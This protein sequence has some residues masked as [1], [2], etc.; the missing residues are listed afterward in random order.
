MKRVLSVLL[1]VCLIVG[2]C[3]MSVSAGGRVYNYIFD[4]NGVRKDASYAYG[5]DGTHIDS[6]GDGWTWDKTTRTLTLSGANFASDN[7][8]F[9]TI[10]LCGDATI[11]LT[12]GTKNT[13]SSARDSNTGAGIYCDGTLTVE[14]KG[15]LELIATGELAKYGEI[16][17]CA[18]ER[19]EIQDGNIS[20]QRLSGK[21]EIHIAGGNAKISSAGYCGYN[22]DGPFD[23]N[24]EGKRITLSI[25]GGVLN[26]ANESDDIMSLYSNSLKGNSL[27][28]T[29]GAVTVAGSLELGRDYQCTDGLLSVSGGTLTVSELRSESLYVTGGTVT[30]TGSLELKT[31]GILSVKNGVLKVEQSRNYNPVIVKRIEIDNAD[32]E[33]NVGFWTGTAAD[34]LIIT[35]VSCEE[36]NI[37]RGVGASMLY[38][39]TNPFDLTHSAPWKIVAAPGSSPSIPTPEPTPTPELPIDPATGKLYAPENLKWSQNTVTVG[40]VDGEEEIHIIPM[41]G[42]IYW[43]VEHPG[44]YEF[45]FKV[46]RKSNPEPFISRVTSARWGTQRADVLWLFRDE[47]FLDDGEY[48]FTV[49]SRANPDGTDSAIDSEVVVSDVW[50][51]KK[52]NQKLPSLPKSSVKWSGSY[53]VW[54]P[55]EKPEYTGGYEL[56]VENKEGTYSQNSASFYYDNPNKNDLHSVLYECEANQYYRYRIKV[57]SNDIN[58]YQHSDWSEWS[59]YYYWNGVDKLPDGSTPTSTPTPT[60]PPTSTPTPTPK[61]NVGNFNDVH[62]GDYFA[63]AV[64]WAVENGIT[65]G[66]GSSSTF[67]P[68]DTCTRAEIMTFIWASEGRPAPSAPADF[69]D[70]PSLPAFR[71]AISWAVEQG[72]TSGMGGGKFGATMPCTRVQAVTFL[73]AAAGRPQPTATAAFSDMTGN[74]VYDAAISWA[75]ENQITTGAGNNRFN[76]GKRCSRAE[77]VT[78]LRAA[79]AEKS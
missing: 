2:L 43:E 69:V 29:G 4:E 45:N 70:M 56:Q 33:S 55:F 17:L 52:P 24:Q 62:E 11:Y 13:V 61:P 22:V 27:N 31:S 6:K 71:S 58:E 40:Y 26:V 3:P 23:S 19:L 36:V 30:I 37:D 41:A 16:E 75:V 51:Y 49:Q 39:G 66:K 59:D 44:T 76:P 10:L 28:I 72:V 7:S 38:G 14:G 1:A 48:Y 54:G 47:D 34:D 65:S 8:G 78:F 46:Y 9:M 50:T 5:V 12:E 20:V 79:S 73:W 42:A 25:S 77:I 18:F 15:S 32:I 35:N 60:P 57:L 63:N 21:N 68:H 74:S 64:L 67:K 53:G